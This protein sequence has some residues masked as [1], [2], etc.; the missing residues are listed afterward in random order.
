MLPNLVLL[1]QM[2][3][4]K[5]YKVRAVAEGPMALTAVAARAPELIL[6]DVDGRVAWEGDPGFR[7][8]ET[9]QPGQPSYLDDP[10]DELVAAADQGPGRE[11]RIGIGPASPW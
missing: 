7:V 1:R 6:L 4:K 9:W 8:G 10:L 5:G 11:R 3:E 2:L